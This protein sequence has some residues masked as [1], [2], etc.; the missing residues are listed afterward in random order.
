[1]LERIEATYST[2]LESGKVNKIK[3]YY[4]KEID[5]GIIVIFSEFSNFSSM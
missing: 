2:C 3:G 4:E 1:M 5:E